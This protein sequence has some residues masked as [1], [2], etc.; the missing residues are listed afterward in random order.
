MNIIMSI[1]YDIM[2]WSTTCTYILCYYCN[3]CHSFTVIANWQ[4]ASIMKLTI[5]IYSIG[6]TF[7]FT[8]Y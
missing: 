7:L 8:E 5:D 2:R 1:C 3:D 4:H 6:I